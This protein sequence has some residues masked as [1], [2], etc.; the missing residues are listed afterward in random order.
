MVIFFLSPAKGNDAPRDHYLYVTVRPLMMRLL[1]LSSL[2][3]MLTAGCGDPPPAETE[4]GPPAPT[5][6]PE[7]C[8]RSSGFFWSEV[9]G[10]CVALF[11]EATRLRPAHPDAN[12]KGSVFVVFGA[13][14]SRAEVW[15]PFERNTRIYE[16]KGNARSWTDG[17]NTVECT[18]VCIFRSDGKVLY[19]QESRNGS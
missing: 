9:R 13:D 7:D 17:K 15:I 2:F 11:T 12:Q 18:D 16:R 14:S 4:S 1:L 8:N 5:V 19:R 6:N 3:A 10:D